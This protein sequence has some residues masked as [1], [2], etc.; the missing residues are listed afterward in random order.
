MG[1]RNPA[2]RNWEYLVGLR[3]VCTGSKWILLVYTKTEIPTWSPGREFGKLVA[4]R[5][6]C[7]DLKRFFPAVRDSEPSR[8]KLGILIGLR[9]AC[10]DSKWILSA[11]TMKERWPDKIGRIERSVERLY[12]FLKS[13]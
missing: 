7:T 4:W 5:I 10:T 13:K 6:A 2:G 11:H 12:G 9:F 1:L 8:T 3:I